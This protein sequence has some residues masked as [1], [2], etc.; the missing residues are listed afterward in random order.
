MCFGAEKLIEMLS[1]G[2]KNWCVMIFSVV[3]KSLCQKCV[4]F[5]F[6]VMIKNLRNV[7]VIFSVMIK[8]LSKECVIFSVMIESLRKGFVS[9]PIVYINNWVYLV[10]VYVSYR[11]CV[12]VFDG[13][14]APAHQTSLS[15][16]DQR[17]CQLR[18]LTPARRTHTHT[19]S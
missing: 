16:R 14:P 13:P 6:S 18:L 5:I 15:R 8:R 4:I 1:D 2:M 10:L 3:L 11:W 19:H 9:F 12:P 17:G 7:F